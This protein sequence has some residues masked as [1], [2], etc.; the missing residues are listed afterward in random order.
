MKENNPIKAAMMHMRAIQLKYSQYGACD[1]EPTYQVE[2]VAQEA[3][4]GNPFTPLD[5]NDWE[6]YTATKKCG[7]AARSMTA[8]AR[9]LHN[10]IHKASLLEVLGACERYGWRLPR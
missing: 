7:T 6:L 1:S 9:K 3:L 8:A 4:K 10:A 2:R 5:A